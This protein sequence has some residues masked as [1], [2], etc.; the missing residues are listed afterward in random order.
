MPL[1]KSIFIFLSSATF[2]LFS[3]AQPSGTRYFPL[4]DDNKPFKINGLIKSRDG[5][6]YAGTTRGLYKFD[7]VRFIVVPFSKAPAKDTITALFEDNSGTMW[8]GFKNGHLAKKINGTFQYIEPEEGTPK[9]AIT[10]FI[11]DTRNNIWLGTNGEGLYYFNN[12][13][14]YLIDEEEGL[15]DKHIHALAVTGDGSVMAATDQGINVCSITGN[16]KTVEQIGPKNGLP[17]YYV[18][19]LQPAGNDK[20]WVGFQQKG[21]CL[22]NHHTKKVDT[23]NLL[24]EWMYSEVNS[25]LATPKSLWLATSENGLLQQSLTKPV[26]S[27]NQIAGIKNNLNNVL[28]DDE[29]NIWMNSNTELICITG[30]KLKLLPLYD[31]A[32]YN[33]IHTIYSDRQNN[34]WVGT[35]GG[36]IRYNF[37][38]KQYNNKFYPLAGFT[39]RTDITSLY[40]DK[41]ENIWIGSMGMGIVVLQ[42]ATGRYRSINENP[43]LKN[44]SILSITGSGNTVCAGGLEGTAVIFEIEEINKDISTPYQFSNYNNIANIGNNY[45]YCVYKD[46]R[47]RIWF[48]T[49]GKGVTVLEN[50]QF[51][52]YDAKN[53]LKDDH[54]LSF[55]EDKKGNIWFSTEYEGVY[56]FNGK[57]FKNYTLANGLSSLNI[58]S[59]ETDAAGNIVIANE[60]GFDILNPVTGVISYL[61]ATQGI[62]GASTDAGNITRDSEENIFLATSNGI[63]VYSA[64][65]NYVAQPK[66]II[67]NVLLFLKDINKETPGRFNYEENSFTFNFTGLYY[68]N[69]QLVR[70]QYKLEGWDTSWLNTKDRSISFPRLSPGKYV[71]HVRSSLNDNFENASEQTYHFIITTPF[72]KRWWFITLCF[73]SVSV[74]LFGYI[75]WR[76][77]NIKRMQQLQQEKIQFQFQVLRNQVNPHFLFN[78]FNTLISTIE[79]NPAMAVDYVEQLSDFFR[80]IVNYQ[81]K[82]I[83]PLSEEI[84]LMQTYFY[85][86]QKRYG[87]NLK[88][89]INIPEAE[90]GETFIPPLTLQLLVENAIKH[91]AVS[92]ESLLSIDVFLENDRLLIKN[93]INPKQGKESGTGMGLQNIIN[94]Y[95]LLSDKPVEIINNGSYFI[96]ALPVLKS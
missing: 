93:N 78:S 64:S 11:Q 21:Y 96:V 13:R 25:L 35:D 37:S 8:L 33:T 49:D 55:T 48:G 84:S 14:L 10:C 20:F 79:E 58:T 3:K 43:L 68:S 50:E 18:T 4:V 72:W 51:K 82:E 83:I 19:A 91:N 27:V 89:N 66:T 53:G 92:K 1:L 42:P 95:R 30:D 6:I 31:K 5:Y 61:N 81:D 67:D 77:R 24:P 12:N 87:D 94:R 63:I 47:N 60:N 52:S 65:E 62:N 59:I 46:S 39:A 76:E 23:A 86:Q 7:G 74:L 90:K 29:G 9:A 36:L 56:Q 88:L 16:K 32:V 34:I 26:S 41:F 57:L 75:K 69:P 85:L 44:A 40:Q 54:I 70:Y 2:I 15:S 17:D 22:Y 71:F 73:L 38:N 28:Q 80:N 45:I